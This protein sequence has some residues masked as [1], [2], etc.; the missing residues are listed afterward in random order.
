[1][2]E[3]KVTLSWKR[4]SDDFSYEKYTR[5]HNWAFDGGVTVNASAAPAYRGD[6]SR[7][8]PEEAFVAAL[9]SC[10]MLTF[11]ALASRKGFVVD[12]YT[13]HAVGILSKNETARLS[14]TTVTLNPVIS[15][16]GSRLPT[17]GEIEELHHRSH[18]ECFIA[19]SVKTD[20]RVNWE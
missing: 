4:T 15:F 8:D 14:V 2:S 17:R 6:P 18:D 7:V 20:V 3:H 11:L 13:D 16:S 12:S 1:M 10:H 5:N 9:S 19:N